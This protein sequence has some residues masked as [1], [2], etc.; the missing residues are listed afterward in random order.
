[1]PI[2]SDFLFTYGTLMSGYDNQF[3]ERL[4]NLS[5]FY[6]KG[7]FPGTLYKVS[8]YPGA[9]YQESSESVVYGE[10]YRLSDADQLLPELDEYEDVFDDETASLYL[11]K[12]VPVTLPDGTILHCW[13]YIYNQSVDDIEIISSGDF[14]K[15]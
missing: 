5:E 15:L 2:N 14:R 9:V 10:I 13:A 1:M 4:K 12:V 11:R 8:W 7:T 3:A 6:D